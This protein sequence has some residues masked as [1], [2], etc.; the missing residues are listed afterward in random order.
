MTTVYSAFMKSQM[1]AGY[2]FAGK[3][4]GLALFFHSP[5]VISPGDLASNTGA[6]SP[7]DLAGLLA[8]QGFQEVSTATLGG[9]PTYVRTTQVAGTDTTTAPGDTIVTYPADWVPIP[10]G[11]SA[12]P[13]FVDA[14]VFYISGT[15]GT[16]TNP[17]IMVTDDAFNLVVYPGAKLTGP[18]D[19]TTGTPLRRLFSYNVAGSTV[20]LTTAM[21]KLLPGIL[22]W[23]SARIEHVYLL[24]QRVNYIPNPSFEDV[25]NFGWRSD[26]VITRNTGGVDSPANHY[27]STT[28]T[29][30]ESIPVPAAPV[31]HFSAWVR[32]HSGSAA[33][34][35]NLGLASLND[36][37]NRMA[38]HWVNAVGSEWPIYANWTRYDGFIAGP[39]N[40]AG[41]V[42]RI[43]A[44]GP[45]D[46][47]LTLLEAIQ[48]L[49][50]Y[51][52]GDSQLGLPGDFSWQGPVAQSYS[53]WYNNR[54]QTAARLFGEYKTGQV[55]KVP[56]LVYD[57][58][59]TGTPIMTH[60]DVLSSTDTKHPLEPWSS[61]DLLYNRVTGYD[62]GTATFTPAGSPTTVAWSYGAG[63][64]AIQGTQVSASAGN[65]VAI[66]LS[67]LTVGNYAALGVNKSN[68][69]LGLQSNNQ[70]TYDLAYAAFA[71]LIATV[72]QAYIVKRVGSANVPADFVIY[73]VRQQ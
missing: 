20:S 23:E 27:L 37:Y 29:V 60:W 15:V 2:N 48:G 55:S 31:F 59:P 56:A 26:G 54:F 18:P 10:T 39:E 30:L 72:G 25:G 24:P 17:W 40:A 38:M 73:N 1:A 8:V 64:A 14:A 49:N 53:F 34:K 11:G 68:G 65:S 67:T 52:D 13:V 44:D 16:T 69:L 66:T 36:S 12:A 3:T 45:F 41:L 47:D 28:G 61:T 22:T 57:W 6:H 19:P 32:K 70:T 58:V 9:S 33:T 7:Y 50:P 5:M 51:Y 43:Q 35:V 4:I 42:P 71:S 63:T 21:I 62:L 46:C